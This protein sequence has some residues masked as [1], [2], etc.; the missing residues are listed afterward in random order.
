MNKNLIY[1]LS[2]IFFS[3]TVGCSTVNESSSLA[4]GQRPEVNDLE[5]GLWMQMENV[6][7]SI[8]R[9]GRLERD[10]KLNQYVKTIVCSLAGKYCPDVRVYVIKA[11]S[12][13]AGMYPNGLMVVY[14]GLLLRVQNEAQ[15]AAVLGHE[16]THFIKRH[17][18]KRLIDI[19]NKA[20]TLA[21]IG[22]PL[23]AI[24]L[25]PVNTVAG[26]VAIGSIAAYSRDHEREADKGGLEF[27]VNR[28]Y[29][30]M[31]AYQI[32]ANVLREQEAD[33]EG[34]TAVFFSSHPLPEERM[35]NI[36]KQSEQYS[37]HGNPVIKED[38]Y[39][40]IIAPFRD[41]WFHRELLR[42]K[43][44][45]T[46]VVIDNLKPS[47]AFPGEKSYF[48]GELIR[49]EKEKDFQMNAIQKYEEAINLDPNDPRP[50]KSVGLMYM[51]I[52][53][54]NQAAKHLKKYLEL[55]PKAED[56][57]IINEYIVQLEND[58]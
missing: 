22:I 19:Q 28:G 3:S 12:F 44:E 58:S 30:A 45:Q 23:A 43:Y 2:L 50:Q 25:G 7:K 36:K 46:K 26:L 41:D 21:V 8:Q 14:T 20:N 31:S 57:F 9:S 24:G 40:Q 15:L 10:P 37:I 27:L 39:L 51:K 29:S 47:K 32:W 5:A 6:E 34:S 35:D 18:L 17:S 13:N 49:M 4:P 53:K 56:A 48:E 16:I 1:F 11:D 54:K 38:E 52:D 55:Q 33:D 42:G